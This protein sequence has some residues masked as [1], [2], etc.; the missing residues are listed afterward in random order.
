M[1]RLNTKEFRENL[2][3][4]LNRV[5]Y[6]GERT[7]ICRNGKE[8]GALVSLEDLQLLVDLEDHIDLRDALKALAEAKEKG[9]VSWEQI[10]TDLKL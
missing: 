8:I 7:I 5:H 2:T 3:D 9:T 6:T 4:T 10:Q 1:T